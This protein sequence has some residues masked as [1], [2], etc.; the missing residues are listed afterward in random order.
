M[1]IFP[2]ESSPKTT[3]STTEAPPEIPSS[4]IP[5]L[6]LT[7]KTESLDD[8][9]TTTRR[10]PPKRVYSTPSFITT[11]PSTTMEIIT[12]TNPSTD[13]FAT[14]NPYVSSTRA[15]EMDIFI[16][17]K[18]TKLSPAPLGDSDKTNIETTTIPTS[19]I[20]TTEGSRR[21]T[22]RPSTTEEVT[23][24]VTIPTTSKPIIISSSTEQIEVY[25]IP[26]GHHG[27]SGVTEVSSSSEKSPEVTIVVETTI[28]PHEEL[29]MA[30][31]FKPK[32]SPQDVPG[33]LML[34][35]KSSFAYICQ[36]KAALKENLFQYITERSSRYA[37]MRVY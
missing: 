13:E 6:K 33:Y 15:T 24:P 5:T 8:I 22:F 25:T 31:T 35:F 27:T 20:R 14:F 19:T 2:D 4:T 3:T 26:S 12:M 11:R 17:K 18:N 30:P 23:E 10:T 7:T 28:H 16:K 21:K 29:P 1:I 32:L 9:M 37:D 36:T 34:I